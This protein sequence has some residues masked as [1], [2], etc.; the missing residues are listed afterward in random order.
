[1]AEY[2]VPQRKDAIEALLQG[3]GVVAQFKGLSSTAKQHAQTLELEKQKE[4]RLLDQQNDKKSAIRSMFGE[5]GGIQ[6]PATGEQ[7]AGG[8]TKPAQ[9]KFGPVT[10]PEQ[11]IGLD[12]EPKDLINFQI[13]Q[14]KEQRDQAKE[15]RDE[16]RA[17]QETK[18]TDLQMQYLQKQIQA[19]AQKITADRGIKLSEGEK[20]VDKKF[21]QSYADFV[22]NGGAESVNNNLAQLRDVDK[23]LQTEKG[24][25][26]TRE[27][28]LSAIPV[29]GGGIR[30]VTSP[31]SVATQQ[32]VEEIIVG[33]LKSILGAQFTEKEGKEFVARAYDPSLP[34]DINRQK[35]Q[36]AIKKMEDMRDAKIASSQY[37][38]EY[39]TLKGFKGVSADQIAKASAN[40]KESLS[41]KSSSVA[42][43]QSDTTKEQVQKLPVGGTFQKS[44]KTYRK[45]GDGKYQEVR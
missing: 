18:K 45:I 44:G 34:Q 16:A 10:T 41:Q 25:T 30:K 11:A 17:T 24:L 42:A 12:L 9:G 19:Q 1:M 28:L 22:L 36:R 31:E 35:L 5:S 20:A 26:G 21:S 2:L 15:K 32:Q 13:Q 39:G 6:P 33:N 3:L 40:E 4:Q 29:V 38:E 14:Q 27:G 37:F 23:K 8:L 7:P 43:S